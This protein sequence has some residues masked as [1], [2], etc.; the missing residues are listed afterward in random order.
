M[1]F[2]RPPSPVYPRK[3]QISL[4]THR[5][6]LRGETLFMFSR[7]RTTILNGEAIGSNRVGYKNCVVRR[8][9]LWFK[10]CRRTHL[11]A[12]PMTGEALWAA[13]KAQTVCYT[14]VCTCT[15]FP[16]G[17]GVGEHSARR[18]VNRNKLPLNVDVIDICLLCVQTTTT[19]N[20]V[21]ACAFRA[22]TKYV[23]TWFCFSFVFILPLFMLRV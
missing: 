8:V 19:N 9:W 16:S 5:S 2:P 18:C 15:R 1:H 21:L 10:S 20:W 6:R 14:Y 11:H 22:T 12:G 3:L 4:K 13:S 7:K 17:I 23:H